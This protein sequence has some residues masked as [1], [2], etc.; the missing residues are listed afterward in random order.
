MKID[1]HK[2][3]YWRKSITFSTPRLLTGVL[4][5]L[6]LWALIHWLPALWRGKGLDGDDQVLAKV[7]GKTIT[8]YDVAM[9]LSLAVGDLGSGALSEQ[10]QKG[11]LDSLVQRKVIARARLKEMGCQEE[12]VL[13]KQ[14]DSF[15]EKL[16]VRQYLAKHAENVKLTDADIQK[17]YEEHQEQFGGRIVKTYEMLAGMTALESRKR[18]E[19]IKSVEKAAGIQ[20]WRKWAAD[21]FKNGYGV[22]Y[23]SGSADERMLQPEIG[24]LLASLQKGQVSPLTFIEG[25]PYLVRVLETR[26]TAAKPLQEVKEDIRKILMPRVYKQAAQQVSAEVMKKARVK[27]Y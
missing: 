27:Y 18:N 17:Y 4:C 8:R 26:I 24:N 11:M 2:Y 16:L 1:L 23:L 6:A 19:F 21:L 9:E 25:K 14:V 20:D 22:R 10:S 13:H 7:H 15:R 3:W 5:L 12:I